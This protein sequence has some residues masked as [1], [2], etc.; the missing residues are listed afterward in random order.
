MVGKRI[1]VIPEASRER[2][3][4]KPRQQP[5]GMRAYGQRKIKFTHGHMETDRVEGL[6]RKDEE[7]REEE[8]EGC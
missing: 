5:S 6:G 4:R 1:Y 7:T 2:E 3:G 8:N